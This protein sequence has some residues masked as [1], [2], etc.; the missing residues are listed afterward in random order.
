MATRRPFS[1]NPQEVQLAA[2]L[3][4]DPL[5]FVRIFFPWGKPG[6][7]ETEELETWQRDFLIDLGRRLRDNEG[8]RNYV[9]RECVLAGHGVGK[10]TLFAWLVLWFMTTRPLC[11]G[12]V[13]AN[14]ESQLRTKTWAELA[15]W[16]GIFA[17]KH[18]FGFEATRLYC[19]VSP[20]NWTMNALPWSESRPESFAGLH[21]DEILLLMDEAS[22]I[23][24]V[25]FETTEGALSSG[26]ITWLMAGNP[27]RKT[28][29]FVKALGEG[30]PWNW[31]RVDARDVRRSNKRQIA[32]WAERWG[33]DSDFY[34]VRVAGFEPT[35]SSFQFIPDS[36]I[37]AAL[38]RWG[39]RASPQIPAVMGVDP[40]R[41]SDEAVFYARRGWET[42]GIRAF[43][44]HDSNELADKAEEAVQ[45]WNI[46]AIICDAAGHGFIDVMRGRGYRIISAD[47]SSKPRKNTYMN[48]RVEMYDEGAQWLREGGSIPNDKLFIEDLRAQQ[49]GE[50]KQTKRLRLIDKDVIRKEL[51][52]SP[53]R[54]DAWAVT[55]YSK[56]TKGRMTMA[57]GDVEVESDYQMTEIRP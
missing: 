26:R 47:F 20:L 51:G 7:L 18:W 57:T 12:T 10:S 49:G 5:D 30:S 24:D 37:D 33:E 9:I 53:D 45:D 21:A 39:Y 3:Y 35:A 17:L 54:G 4:H 29:T 15:K 13:T 1:L 44:D 16:L 32:E 25:I 8:E 19:P 28:G 6:P 40:A 23:P 52:R 14:T 41:L 48:K 50:Q 27:T 22:A 38:A 11:R 34:R 36:I 46:D 55:F 56:V 2:Q 31:R 42:I 43:R